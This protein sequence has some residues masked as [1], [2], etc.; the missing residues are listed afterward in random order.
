MRFC[1]YAQRAVLVAEAKGIPH[2]IVNAN[3]KQKPEWLLKVNPGGKVPTILTPKGPLYESLIV[4]DYFDEVYPNRPLNS[5]DP[6]QKAL[7]RI[8]VD[9]FS[10]VSTLYH[11][12][13]FGREDLELVKGLLVEFAEVLAPFEAELKRRGTLYFGGST[14]PG[15][16]DYMIWPWFERIPLLKVY[17]PTL[18]DYEAAKLQNP[19]LEKWR[20]AMKEDPAVKSFHVSTENHHKFIESMLSGTNNYN[21]YE[22]M[23]K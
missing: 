20:Q 14:Q 22:F 11:K 15:M 17:F 18:Y 3:L 16:L 1:P 10:K 19:S 5:S 21:D 2:D 7:D 9:H 4:A 12:M 8:W 23:E 6:F 13:L